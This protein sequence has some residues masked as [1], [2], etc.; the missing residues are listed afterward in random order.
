MNKEQVG[1]TFYQ[2]ETKEALVWEA[3]RWNDVYKWS[4]YVT[5]CEEK[6]LGIDADKW[7]LEAAEGFP[8]G[9]KPRTGGMPIA[10]DRFA[11]HRRDVWTLWMGGNNLQLTTPKHLNV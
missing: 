1:P 9:T 8:E 5:R 3:I 2:M 4:F 6:Q 11:W 10:Q 7:I